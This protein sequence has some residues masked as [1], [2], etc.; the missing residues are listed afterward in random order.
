MEVI[1]LTLRTPG[2]ADKIE[3]WGVSDE[4][5]QSDHRKITFTLNT[6]AVRTV[7]GPRRDPKM[8]D[9]STYVGELRGKIEHFPS[10]YGSEGEI[11]LAIEIL[12]DSII[13]SYESNCTPKQAYRF[14]PPGTLVERTTARMAG[15][16]QE[17][18]ECGEGIR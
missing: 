11:D 7:R 13:Q 17:V 9:W 16:N 3:K 18:L 6:T 15:E 12:R 10:R 1:D 4:P 14:V 2:M 5:S 8:T